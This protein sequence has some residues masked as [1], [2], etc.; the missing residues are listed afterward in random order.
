MKTQIGFLE[1]LQANGMIAKS[2]NRLQCFLA[3]M[4]AFFLILVTVFFG[5]YSW[6]ALLAM[7]KEK[8]ITPTEMKV[9]LA[10]VGLVDGGLILIL[11]TYAFGFKAYAKGQELKST[12][13]NTPVLPPVPQE[14]PQ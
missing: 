7:V 5:I 6:S 12:D 4:M 13:E 9:M 8:I 1:E 14:K 11:L 2:S 10:G 3:L